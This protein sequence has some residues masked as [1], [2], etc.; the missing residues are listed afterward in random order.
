MIPVAIPIALEI[1]KSVGLI[2]WLAS[3]FGDSAPVAKKV[4]D[5]AVAVSGASNPSDVVDIL[6]RDPVKAAQVAEAIR[7]DEMELTRLA[8]EDLRDARKTYREADH[9]Q[10]DKIAEHVIRWNAPLVGMLLSLY[11]AAY[12]FVKDAA[13]AQ[14]IGALLGG[15]I[16]ALWGE[17]Q[18][19]IGFFFGSSLGSK[20]KS[21]TIQNLSK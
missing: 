4:I 8:Y 7:A 15:S 12:M 5:I 13:A 19:V 16:T 3:K 2:D 21:Q 17:R 1:A 6:T 14:A 20:D 9:S 10:A 11:G 18:A